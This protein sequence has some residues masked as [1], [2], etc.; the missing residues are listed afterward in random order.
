MINMMI[1]LYTAIHK[2]DGKVGAEVRKKI[3]EGLE[4]RFKKVESTAVYCNATIFDPRFKKIGFSNN[5]KAQNAVNLAKAE[6]V[7]VAHEKDVE[8]EQNDTENDTVPFKDD[9]DN[10]WSS[11]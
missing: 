10:L 7:K 11:F 8:L 2:T 4:S 1:D 6:A 3:G 9:S 5:S